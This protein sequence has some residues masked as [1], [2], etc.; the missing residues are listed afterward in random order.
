MNNPV[1]VHHVVIS[2]KD[3]KAQLEFFTQVLGAPLVGLFDMHG[4]E[5][6][7]HAFVQLDDYCH[8]SFVQVPG[9]EDIEP[10]IGVSHSGTGD[11]VSAPGTMQHLAFAARTKDEL[12]ALRDR[13]RSAGVIT[14]GP[15]EHGMC[16]SIY[17][18]GPEGLTLEVAW[19][20][21]P[22]DHRAWVDPEVAAGCGIDADELEAMR[23]PAPFT[24]PETPV[25]QPGIDPT[26]PH[27]AYPEERYKLM[28][29]LDDETLINAGSYEEPPV[30]V[31]AAG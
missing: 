1:G 2:T 10:I 17:F 25:A 20:P 31:D 19:A 8:V 26:K 18:A 30:E 15:I 27:L 29:S 23:H 4:V 11:G 12:L 28:V 5:G 24:R 16:S 7:Y 22:I 6:A 21:G 13:L 9:M 3:M 14:F